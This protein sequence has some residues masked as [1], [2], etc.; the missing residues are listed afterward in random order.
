MREMFRRLANTAILPLL[1]A[2]LALAVVHWPPWGPGHAWPGLHPP[3]R[4]SL[5]R[6]A[7]YGLAA[8]GL[9]L[10]LR[11]RSS[12]L[13]IAML[14]LVAAFHLAPH[15][16]TAAA[17]VL[18]F[19]LLLAAGTLHDQG[20][21]RRSLV[22]LFLSLGV[23]G[24]WALLQQ[25]APGLPVWLRPWLAE[26]RVLAAGAQ[27]LIWRW[28]PVD[29]HQWPDAPANLIRWSGVLLLLIGA[30]RAAD[31]GRA[32]LG[33][34][35]GLSAP[36]LARGIDA[37]GQA[38]LAAA[39]LLAVLVGMLESLLALAYRDALTGLP[40]RRSLNERLRRL[41]RRYAIAMMDVDHFKR[42]NDRYG[43]K[44]GDQVLKMIAARLRGV[45]SG[46]AYRYGGE[47]FAVVF[48]GRAAA[49]AE[50]ELEQFR[51]ELAAAPFVV[52]REPR[53]KKASRGR[54]SN[55]AARRHKTRVTA[56]IGLAL[57]GRDGRKPPEVLAAADKALYI[58]KQKGRNQTCLSRPR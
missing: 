38:L 4:P 12:G 34:G 21:S 44:T 35:L 2:L 26:G 29:P 37:N 50:A 19:N 7:P 24:V 56:S 15:A 31:A 23:L 1:I 33:A 27:A 39:A 20:W 6:H 30:L 42:F 25:P 41:G 5:L 16:A 43:H 8:V 48:A 28:L 51:R 32:G 57:A 47:E 14:S 13:L 54:N 46:Q 10:G 55:S 40:G 52:R 17:A 18:T 11:I 53:Q 9:L 36:A 22:A 45:R 3:L 49:A 58:A